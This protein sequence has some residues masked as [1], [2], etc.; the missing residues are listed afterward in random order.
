[1]AFVYGDEEEEGYGVQQLLSSAKEDKDWLI[2]IRRKIHENPEL[3]FQEHNTSALI[4]NELQ[5]WDFLHLSTCTHWFVAQIGTGSPPI[6][7]LRADMDALPLQELVEWEHKSKRDGVMHGCGHDAHTTM[8]LGAAK[9]LNQRKDHLKGTV[10]LIFQPAEE[11]GAGASFMIKE[12][13]LGGAEAIF[14]MHI[15]S[16]LPTGSIATLPGPMLA[17]TSFFAA[18][19]EGKGGHAAEPHNSVDPVLA[20]SSTVLALQQLISRELDP[21]QS[22]VLS[23]TYVR[24]GEALNVIPPYVELGGTLRS[25]TTEGL[26]HLQQRVKEVIE[27]QAAVHRCKGSVNM[28][29]DKFP[30]YPA[31]VND[32]TLNTHVNNVGSLLLGAERVKESK[33]VMAGEDFAFYQ[34]KIP[35]VMF[36]IGILNEG[37]GSFH[38]PHSPYFFLDEDVLPIGAALHTAIAELY[39]DQ[40]QTSFT[41]EPK[42]EEVKPEEKKEEVKAEE[43]KEEAKPEEAKP[44]EEKK[45]EAKP[46]E[47]KKE[48]QN[49]HLPWCYLHCVGC[50]KKIEKSLFRI[51]GVVGVETDMVKN[52]VTIKGVVEPQAVCDKITKK[53]KRNAKVLSPLPAAEGEPI[54]EVVASQVPGLITVELNVNMHCE[55]CAQQLKRK[56]LRMKGVRTVE[57][58]V[59]SSKVIVTGS[60]DGEKLVEYV[61]RRTKKQAKIVPQP[62]PEPEAAAPEAEKPKEEEAAA[63]AAEKKPAEEGKPPEEK[64]AAEGEGEEK[65]EGGKEDDGVG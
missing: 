47:E 57:T 61:Y 41:E 40:H 14:G 54:P 11:G 25:L 22:Q 24:A 10:R 19:I 9:L 21:L 65:K 59:S 8:L 38:S 62:E 48:N 50:A 55:A 3:R 12:G 5:T 6:V 1:M 15:D 29:D 32:E 49:H 20:A 2:S 28:K 7:A 58:E 44:E 56:I 36:G 43:K 39:L 51:P 52:Q 26:Q 42:A 37:I 17:A 4:R 46:E 18:R 23:V 60:M 45:E 33:K 30:P 16:S 31:T 35:G 64:A 27:A 63:K 13:A 53:T 34:Q